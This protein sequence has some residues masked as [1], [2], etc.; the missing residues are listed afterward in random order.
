MKRFMMGMG[1]LVLATLIWLP[2]VH[3]FAKRDVDDFFSSERV[4]PK[5][6]TMAA[7]HLQFWLDPKLREAELAR[8]RSSNPEW[9]FMGRTFLVLALANMALSEPDQKSNY[10]AIIDAVVDETIRLETEHGKYYFLMPYATSAPFRGKLGRSVFQD[11]EIALMI[12]ARRLVEDKDAYKPLLTERVDLMIE[13]MKE[14]EVLSAESYPNECWMFC[15]TVALAA[16]R[17]ADVLD[18]TDH[19]DFIQRW[20][21]MA[22]ARLTDEKSGL[23]ISSY[24]FD[25]DHMDGPEGSTIWMVAHCLQVVDKA[26]AEDQYARAKKELAGQ[27][28]GFG[29]AREWPDSWPGVADVDSGPVIP[30]LEVSAGSSGLAFLGASAFKD[31][32]YLSSLLTSLTFG[33]FPS[34]K[35]GKLRYYASNQVGDAVLLYAMVVGPLWDKVAEYQ[36][37]GVSE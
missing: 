33:G 19:S 4:A 36:K 26:Y 10:L 1:A 2:A 18:G 31:R 12:A 22:K 24:S 15:N 29:Y 23:L 37:D 27:T 35:D 25:G 20:I 30:V 14:G 8:M 9:D 3:L 34:E 16:I 13:C 32:D 28:L 17:I 11:G 7:Q 21:Q 6:R 5:A